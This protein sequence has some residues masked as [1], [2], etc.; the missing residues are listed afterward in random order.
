MNPPRKREAHGEKLLVQFVNLTKL[1]KAKESDKVF[2]Q[3]GS[4][5][6][7]LKKSI[8]V[9]PSGASILFLSMEF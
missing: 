6:E 5:I 8:F 7:K 9:F 2:M 3:Q 1:R 4:Q